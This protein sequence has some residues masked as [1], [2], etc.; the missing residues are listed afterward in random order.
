MF[1]LRLLFVFQRAVEKLLR[2][3]DI[4]G[5]Q[6]DNIL[7]VLRRIQKNEVINLQLTAPPLL[8]EVENSFLSSFLFAK[9]SFSL[10]LPEA[11]LSLKIH[12]TPQPSIL[13]FAHGSFSFCFDPFIPI[14]LLEFSRISLR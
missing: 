1:E 13:P 10:A 6:K 14:I 11:I 5:L 4:R 3:S 9:G 12:L 8:A 2:R 7:I